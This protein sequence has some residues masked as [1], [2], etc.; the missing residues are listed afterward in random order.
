M[1]DTGSGIANA[2]RGADLVRQAAVWR[3]DAFVAAA[4]L[5]LVS[6]IVV[7]SAAQ[8]YRLLTSEKSI[9]L[10]ES[11]FVPITAAQLAQF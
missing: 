9:D 5:L 8:W 3:F 6:L 11:E 1:L 4:F 2:S 10:H 7:G